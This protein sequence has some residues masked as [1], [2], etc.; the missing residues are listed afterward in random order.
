[1]TGI[2]RLIGLIGALGFC[3]ASAGAEVPQPIQPQVS[4]DRPDWENPAINS[5]NE[6]PARATGFPFES[7][8][9]A[10]RNDMAASA[11]HRSLDGLWKF[12]FSPSVDGRPRDFWRD[13]FDVSGW[14]DIRVPANWQ[15]EGYGQARFNNINYPFPANRPLIPHETN[16]VGSYRRSFTMPPEWE[17]SDVILHIGAAGA[18]Y[19]VW[20]NGNAVGYSE[21]SKLPS[22]FNISRYVRPGSNS[23]AMEVYRWSDGSYLEDQDFW[24]VSGIERSV[25]LMAAPRLRARDVFINAGLDNDHRDGVLI[26]DAE[27]TPSAGAAEVR[28]TLLDGDAPPVSRSTRVRRGSSARTARLGA[29]VPNVRPWSAE[30]PNLYTLLLEVLDASGTLVQATSYRIGFRTVEIRDGLVQVNGRPITIRGVNRHEHDPETFHVISEESMRRDIELMKQNNINAVRL[31]HYPNDERFYALADEYGLYVMDEANIE[32]HAYMAAGN[33]DPSRRERLQIGFDPAWEDAHVGRVTDMVERDKNHPS[34]LFWSLGNEA[35]LGPSFESAAAAARRI[36][37]TRLISYLGHGTADLHVP[38]DYVDI[39][40]PMYDEVEKLLDYATDPRFTQPLIL[41]EYAHMQ[42]NSGGMLG[43]YWEVI[44][45]HPNRLQGGFV[46]DWVDQSLYGR[47]EDGRST[48]RI[49]NAFGPNPG[50]DIEF[51]DGLVQADRTPNPH[52]FELRKV[53]EPI[54]FEA[55]DAAAGRFRV[56]N[57][58]DFRDLSGFSFGWRLLEDGLPVASGQLPPV[59]AGARGSTELIVD[60]PA[61]V[62]PDA[63]RIL[64]L[65]ATAQD[66]AVPLVP[67]GWVI[68]WEQFILDSAAPAASPLPAGRVTVRSDDGEVRLSAGGEELV[69][70]RSTGLIRRYASGS[71]LLLQGGA[72]NFYRALTDNDLAAGVE[73]SHRGWR[74][75]SEQRDL[76]A[77]RFGRLSDGSA[78]IVVDHVMGAGAVRF[79]TRYHMT[80]SGRVR[81]AASFV[82][83]KD[84]LPDPLRVG[85]SFTMPESMTDVAWYGRGPHETYVDRQASGALGV[86]HGRVA[87]QNHDYLRPQETG[88]KTDVRWID[89]G[90]ENGLGLRVSG[91]RPL[92]VNVLAFPYSDLERRPPGTWL[93]GDIRPREPVSLMV[94]AVQAG[95]GGDDTW[96]LAAR[97]HVR[98]RIPLEP[99]SFSFELSPSTLARGGRGEPG[100]AP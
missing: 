55:I 17:A 3:I 85:L 69:I 68:A 45:A 30:T 97:P 89:V 88:N 57:R 81:V 63:E 84:D 60:L 4:S 13:D 6:E 100:G 49:G 53:Y 5:R 11:R 98:Y 51:G 35:G 22:E 31:S 73:S 86:W 8:E 78:E 36:D 47:T 24:R 82:P 65:E 38:N 87:A 26:V 46:W 67:E 77:L 59:N 96:S 42:A 37:P 71:R 58:H 14:D 28:I 99:L 23:V 40:A 25:W 52:L 79:E 18:A 76:R 70:D 83:I 21:D 66:G 75:Y 34:I 9:L 72:P 39:Y 91:T 2:R 95:V 64:R 90:P 32:S 43:A 74:I 41:G 10:L 62:N 80:Q 29:T 48:W 7:R 92:S 33:A 50:G 20:V 12:H 16:P 27:L 1:M 54:A 44:R 94:D 15:A 93:S 61:P 56:A 19:Y